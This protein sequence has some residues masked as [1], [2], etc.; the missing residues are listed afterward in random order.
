MLDI[1]L[2][3][4]AI[5]LAVGLVL[6]LALLAVSRT[7]RFTALF[8][9]RGPD[10]KPRWGGLVFLG[11]FAI[12]PFL[13]AAVSDHASEFFTPRAG[14]FMGFVAA[15]TLVFLVG[16]LDDIRLASPGLRS[17]VELVAATAVYAAGYRIDDIG[18]PVGPEIHLGWF[19]YFVT[20]AWIW[21][22]TNAFNIIDGRDGV[23]LGVAIFA[24]VTLAV[25]AG[26]SSHPTVALLLVAL[27]GAG[28]GFLPFNLP[29]A[30]AYVGDSGAY[31]LG[32]VIGTL[33]IR[34]A[35]GPTDAVF[36]A[37]P[38]IALGFPLLDFGFA[39]FRRILDGRHPMIGDLDHIHN[40]LEASG[41]GPRGLLAIIYSFAAM[42]SL[43]AILL[44]YVDS[45]YLEAA[46]FVGLVALVGGIL[47]KLGY[48]VTVWNSQSIVWLRQRVFAPE[49]QSA[50]GD[51][52]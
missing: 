45:T 26:H 49:P 25:V 42:F 21:A 35:T 50:P 7:T 19:G 41:A 24:A 34:A 5:A 17:L 15:V 12:S 20:I 43:G 38:I 11:T 10:E 8:D 13:A 6:T 28:L 39:A 31:V 40:R 23:A 30:S 16:F 33:S 22:I 14:S 29:P 44:H 36:V 47:F 48:L 18:F 37:V 3:T 51:R 4:L 9:V 52:Q 32:F 46:V 27:V 1:Y 2:I